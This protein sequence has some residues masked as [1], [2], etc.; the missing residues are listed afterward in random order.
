[1][2]HILLYFI[3]L[4]SVLAEEKCEQFS[5]PLPKGWYICQNKVALKAHVEYKE[6]LEPV[7]AEL[8]QTLTAHQMVLAKLNNGLD[9]KDLELA[10]KL[11][12]MPPEEREKHKDAPLFQK[13]AETGMF[14]NRFQGCP[15]GVEEK[16]EQCPLSKKVAISKQSV[17]NLTI[18]YDETTKALTVW[19]CTLKGIKHYVSHVPSTEFNYYQSCS[20]LEVASRKIDKTGSVDDSLIGNYVLPASTLAGTFLAEAQPTATVGRTEIYLHHD[21]EQ[22]IKASVERKCPK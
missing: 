6:Y 13:I 17:R 16:W 5:S 2:K 12:T 4:T 7:R 19:A 1:M 10:R 18:R 20:T 15:K 14:F 21:Q 8:V 9:L 11:A 22:H 3:L